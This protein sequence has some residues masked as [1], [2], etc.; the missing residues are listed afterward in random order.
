MVERDLGVFVETGHLVDIKPTSA[1]D[2]DR[3]GEERP[4]ERQEPLDDLAHRKPGPSPESP[5]V[6][7]EARGRS[8]VRRP[9]LR[10]HRVKMLHERL[11]EATPEVPERLAVGVGQDG[12][13]GTLGRGR[14]RAPVGTRQTGRRQSAEPEVWALVSIRREQPLDRLAGEAPMTAGRR[15]DPQTTVV[16]PAS[17][18]PLGYPEHVTGLPEAQPAWIR[19]ESR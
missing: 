12:A 16:S 17:K 3:L 13:P 9:L 1:S 19:C 2:D 5:I 11:R 4:A 7:R 8:Q 18:R 10:F 14:G 6:G 15:E